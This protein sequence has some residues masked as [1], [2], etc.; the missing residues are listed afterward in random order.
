[1]Y[2]AHIIT[3]D[4]LTWTFPLVWILI[5]ACAVQ[6]NRL[7]QTKSEHCFVLLYLLEQ[8][9]AGTI[10]GMSSSCC[11]LPWYSS[12]T[13]GICQSTDQIVGQDEKSLHLTRSAWVPALS[14][15]IATEKIRNS[16]RNVWCII[17]SYLPSLLSA[18]RPERNIL[19]MVF[20][21]NRLYL[22]PKPVDPTTSNL[23]VPSAFCP[24]DVRINSRALRSIFLLWSGLVCSKC[25]AAMHRINGWR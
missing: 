6:P 7:L 25:V 19:D 14:S 9:Y 21:S 17:T 18:H 12:R 4:F 1:M 15:P 5:Y 13:D 11:C 22:S 16:Q 23:G 20:G 8:P 3:V 2:A 24:C 10:A